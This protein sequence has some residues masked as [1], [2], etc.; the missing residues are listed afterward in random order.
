MSSVDPIQP[1]NNA[2]HQQQHSCRFA[3]CI[4][5][6]RAADYGISQLSEEDE[7]EE[8]QQRCERNSTSDGGGTVGSSTETMSYCEGM[9]DAIPEP[10]TPSHSGITLTNGT[11]T[12]GS[13][14]RCARFSIGGSSLRV[15][16][17]DKIVDL[18][19]G[20]KLAS[21]DELLLG[22]EQ[23]MQKISLDTLEDKNSDAVRGEYSKFY[24]T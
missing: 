10:P 2:P 14:E 6:D 16:T 23:K 24:D 21:Q 7:A 12:N 22:T 1:H 17:S 15:F 3:I 9:K 8:L 4:G 20:E 19:S 18:M 11:L 5:F 13:N